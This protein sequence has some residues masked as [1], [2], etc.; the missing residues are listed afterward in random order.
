MLQSN[1]KKFESQKAACL[2]FHI[3]SDND[4]DVDVDAKLN[5]IHALEKVDSSFEITQK[6]GEN[7]KICIQYI[8]ESYKLNKTNFKCIFTFAYNN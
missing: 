4:D 5:D 7:L 8:F 3:L 1:R 2:F 6:S